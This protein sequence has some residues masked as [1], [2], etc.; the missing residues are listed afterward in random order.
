[1]IKREVFKSVIP[2]IV[3][4]LLGSLI[5]GV[6]TSNHY[7]QH[8]LK[9]YNTN[10]GGFVFYK[11]RIYSLSELKNIW[12]NIFDLSNGYLQQQEH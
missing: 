8:Y 1:M 12:T 11:G 4:I 5:T 10:I 3:G 7:N 9:V 6:L 2:Y